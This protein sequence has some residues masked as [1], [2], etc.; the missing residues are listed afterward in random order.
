[1]FDSEN[2]D[3]DDLFA[4]N[5]LASPNTS[6]E[7][8]AAYAKKLDMGKYSD[9]NRA[10]L[11][12]QQS[13]PNWGGAL[14]AGLAGVA[15]AFQGKDSGAASA[16]VLNRDERQNQIKLNQFDKG[17]QDKIQDYALGQQM[18]KDE[19]ENAKSDPNS[20][21]SIAFRK[22]IE[23]NFPKVAKSYGDNWSNVTAADQNIIFDPLKLKEQTDARKEAAMLANSQRGDARE[24]RKL[25]REQMDNEKKQKLVTPFGLA[26]S[27]D[28]AKKL[29]DAF[30]SKSNFDNKIDEM[31][32]LREK[33]GGGDVWN[34]DD[35]ARGKQLS[36]DLL[37]E[38]KNMAKLGVL[39]ASD[40]KI[41][42]AIIPADPL[43][44][45][46]PLAAM[47]GEDPILGN[48]KKF[49]GDSDKDFATRVGTR[50]RAGIGSIA[51]QRDKA[52]PGAGAQGDKVQMLSPNG[53]PKMVSRKDVQKALDAGGKVV[54]GSMVG[55]N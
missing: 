11:L 25:Q 31:I 2:E 32:S 27:E 22:M 42:N 9:E 45:N 37:L 20:E 54:E 4:Q 15:A 40:E 3:D 35:V 14:Q 46:S 34:R 16:D 28:D 51:G 19:R 47:R 36:K 41:I 39:S 44:Y 23:A 7:L 12:K 5:V 38:Y 8:K 55:G 48:L 50:T 52:A 21:P 6:P 30:E 1:M 24:D 33:H 43:E 29:K 13:D 18:T 10:H 53:V 49:K 17:R 26:N